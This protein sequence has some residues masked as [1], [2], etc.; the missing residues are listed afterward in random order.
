MWRKKRSVENSLVHRLARELGVE[1]RRNARVNYPRRINAGLPQIAFDGYPMR[2]YDISAGGCALHDP[3][4]VLGKDIGVEV[5]LTIH[6]ADRIEEV[7]CRLVG[8]VDHRR[9]I[10]FL[11]LPAARAQ[12][13][14]KQIVPGVC[15]S[16]LKNS[17]KAEGAAPKLLAHEVWSSLAGDGLTLDVEGPRL[18]QAAFAGQMNTIHR[19]DWPTGADGRPLTQAQLN[20]L[21]LFVANVRQPTAAVIALQDELEGL[22]MGVGQ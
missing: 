3:G 19:T 20:D 14:A 10:Q 2:A 11:N 12:V 4:E 17:F 18:A 6:F 13:I 7:Q 21:I 8:R 5:S 22:L 9:H 15:G 1:R 16:V